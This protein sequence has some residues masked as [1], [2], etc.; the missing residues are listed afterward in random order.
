MT[1]PLFLLRCIEI[2][3]SIRDSDEVTI[4]LVLDIWAEKANDSVRYKQVA[5]QE[6][7]DRF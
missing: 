4:G 6:E 1:T 3:L 7:F 5:G 2:G